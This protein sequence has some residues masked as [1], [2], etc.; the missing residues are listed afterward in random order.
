MNTP[1]SVA[2]GYLAVAIP[3]LVI[4]ATLKMALQAWKF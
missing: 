2:V 1:E 3:I 4:S